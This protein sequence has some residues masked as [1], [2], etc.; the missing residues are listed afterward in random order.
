M[1]DTVVV[2]REG[3]FLVMIIGQLAGLEPSL[4]GQAGMSTVGLSRLGFL[5]ALVA[6]NST[7]F[8]VTDILRAVIPTRGNGKTP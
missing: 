3:T 2:K 8:E 4:T 1:G 7:A 6:R 5:M